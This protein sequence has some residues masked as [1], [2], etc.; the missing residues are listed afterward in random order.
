MEDVRKLLH[1]EPSNIDY[2]KITAALEHYEQ[3][4]YPYMEVP[5]VVSSEA[6]NVTL[7]PEHAAT[8]VQYGDLVGSAEQSFIELML[9][10]EAVTKACAIT[11][12]F[13]LEDAY[14]ELHHGYFMK[15]ELINT[16]VTDANLQATIADAYE[17]FAHYLDVEIVPTGRGMYD[18]VDTRRKIELGSYGVRAY[19]E[20]SF[21]YGTG[22][23]LP[24]LDKAIELA[25]QPEPEQNA[26]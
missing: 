9:R 25:N 14:D 21:I 4:G 22:V 7:P 23:A 12:C 17:F 8:K 6:L 2:R 19:K 26:L 24:R 3:R 15:L 18:I 20:M 13:R 10:G 1:F 11:P 5:W 16:E